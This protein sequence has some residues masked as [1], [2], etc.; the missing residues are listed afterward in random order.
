MQN[1]CFCIKYS[2]DFLPYFFPE[3]LSLAIVA[4]KTA[5]IILHALAP[6]YFNHLALTHLIFFFFF[7]SRTLWHAGS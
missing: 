1:R 6:F 5:L 2:Y 3:R 4:N 7:F